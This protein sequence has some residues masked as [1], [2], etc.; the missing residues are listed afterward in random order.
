MLYVATIKNH[1]SIKTVHLLL[2]VGVLRSRELMNSN[3]EKRANENDFSM[4]Y[5]ATIDM[6]LFSNIFCLCFYVCMICNS[7]SEKKAYFFDCVSTFHVFQIFCLLSVDNFLPD[8][9]LTSSPFISLCIFHWSFSSIHSFH[10]PIFFFVIFF[11]APVLP[12]LIA[13][14]FSR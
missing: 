4:R 12:P 11:L 8:L 14:P 5:S 10:L 9:F 1:S 2:L 6:F 13:V 3:K 7:I